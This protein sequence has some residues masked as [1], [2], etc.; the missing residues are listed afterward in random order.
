MF[1]SQ[2]IYSTIKDV[3]GYDYHIIERMLSITVHLKIVWYP[4]YQPF[5]PFFLIL[6]KSSLKLKENILLSTYHPMFY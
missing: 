2:N 1:S 4:Y 3:T 5:L 6:E